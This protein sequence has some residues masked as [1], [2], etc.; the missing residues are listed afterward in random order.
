MGILSVKDN[1][2][3]EDMLCCLVWNEKGWMRAI[4]A[5]Y[6]KNKN[7]FILE[8]IHCRHALTLEVTHYMRVPEFK[9]RDD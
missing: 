6:W 5:R 7:I 4:P 8:D 3:E 2:P 9:D 1:P